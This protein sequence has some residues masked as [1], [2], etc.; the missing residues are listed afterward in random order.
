MPCKWLESPELL[1]LFLVL[2]LLARKAVVCRKPERGMK[3]LVPNL[4]LQG[5]G[6]PGRWHQASGLEFG[7]DQ[8][9]YGRGGHT[10][11]HKYTQIYTSIH[12]YTQVYTS[13][14]TPRFLKEIFNNFFKLA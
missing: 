5:F 1:P 14:H 2:V 6:F 4:A 11:T 13:I 9:M 3:G 10:N 12:K 7:G 8:S